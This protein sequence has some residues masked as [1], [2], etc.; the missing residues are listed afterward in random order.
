MFELAMLCIYATLHLSACLL[1][2]YNFC[3]GKK[4]L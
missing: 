2:V 3:R 4:Q 1:A